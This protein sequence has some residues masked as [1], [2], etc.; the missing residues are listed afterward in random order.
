VEQVPEVVVAVEP[1]PLVRMVE[2]TLAVL[3]EQDKQTLTPGLASL[4]LVV[5]AEA[6]AVRGEELVVPVALAGVAQEAQEE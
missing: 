3:V 1:V 2:Q 5:V 4:A 6:Q